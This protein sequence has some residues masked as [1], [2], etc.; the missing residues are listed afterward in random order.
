MIRH[1]INRADAGD[2]FE[3]LSPGPCRSPPSRLLVAMFL[4]PARAAAV[5]TVP[6]TDEQVLT[7]AATHCMAC[8]AQKPS[9]PSFTK[10]PKGIQLET[11]DNFHRYA[12]Q[13]R[14][15]AVIGR[16]HAARQYNA[17]H[18]SRAGTAR[19]LDHGTAMR[20]AES[21]RS[22]R[23]AFV[24]RFG[25]IAEHSPW[26]AER[27]A[28]SRPLPIAKTWS[29]PFSAPSRLRRGRSRRR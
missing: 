23:R 21:T 14:Q 20:L 2:R 19:R 6:V 10:P 7:I 13:V 18:R 22:T 5:C 16:G 1:F 28:L 26:V 24:A 27:A 12:S 9:N 8:H 11:I 3:D 17:H 29:T 25:D 15:Q 4:P